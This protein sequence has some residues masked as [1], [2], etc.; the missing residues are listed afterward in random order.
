VIHEI[1]NEKSDHKVTN[2]LST[3][4]VISWIGDGERRSSI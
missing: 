3:C 1:D 2:S 4:T